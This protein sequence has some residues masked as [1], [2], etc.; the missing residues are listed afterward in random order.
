MFLPHE[1]LLEIFQYLG[2]KDLKSTRLSS[3]YFN[4]AACRSLFDTVY[5]C[6]QSVDYDVLVS[7]SKCPNLSKWVKTLR[8]DASQFPDT[9]SKSTYLMYLSVQLW[10]LLSDSLEAPWKSL[11]SNAREGVQM[12]QC[13]DRGRSS[14]AI[15]QRIWD[16]F[17]NAQFVPNGYNKFMACAAQQTAANSSAQY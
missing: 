4:L 8:Y 2:K 15:D 16:R 9:F 7:I 5:I 1:I 14:P 10:R 3:R 17:A 13:S 11:E 12:V 6:A